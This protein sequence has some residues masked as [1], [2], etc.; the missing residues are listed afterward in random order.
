LAQ[1]IDTIHRSFLPFQENDV[2]ITILGNGG[3]LNDGLLYNAFVINQRLLCEVPPDIMYS[4]HHNGIDLSGIDT[5]FISHLHGD[6]FFG[7]PFLFLSACFLQAQ[8]DRDISFTIIGPEGIDEMTEKLM[9]SAFTPDHPC[10][11]WMKKCCRFLSATPTVSPFM[12]DG[13]RT[14]IFKLDHM[15]DTYG[16]RLTCGSDAPA[17]TYFADTRWC[18][19]VVAELSRYPRIVIVDLNGRDDDPEPVHL[20]LK[21]L[22]QKA[23][24]ITGETTRYFGTHLKKEFVSENEYITCARPGMVISLNRGKIRCRPPVT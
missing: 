19:T 2:E 12:V 1:S 7:L 8:T 15:V 20:S 21:E 22:M 10:F 11:A 13:Y 4:I 5:I 24:P 16:F 6:H 23:L 14:S 3:A 18:D 9:V 17:F